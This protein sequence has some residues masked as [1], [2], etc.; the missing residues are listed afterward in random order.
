MLIGQVLSLGAL[1][2][3]AA[4]PQVDCIEA[5]S[6]LRKG[7][8]PA[9]C[10]IAYDIQFQGDAHRSEVEVS[11][12]SDGDFMY[13]VRDQAGQR[14][15]LPTYFVAVQ[16]DR[17]FSLEGSNSRHMIETDMT[18]HKKDAWG[19]AQWILCPWSIMEHIG[20][21]MLAGGDCQASWVDSD[22]LEFRSAAADRV[23]RIGR[24]GELKSVE[25][26]KKQ[27]SYHAVVAYKYKESGGRF[28]P[29]DILESITAGAGEKVRSFELHYRVKSWKTATI[30]DT[31]PD[32]F[33]PAALGVLRLDPSSGDVSSLDGK[34]LY[35]QA[36]EQEKFERMM[37]LTVEDSY[38]Y[39]YWISGGLAAVALV[40]AWKRRRSSGG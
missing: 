38:G 27:S 19:P 33:D 24:R 21:K 32:R 25:A 20:D 15:V 14:S 28:V 10:S 23:L 6:L 37:D 39:L 13:T 1:G 7:G 18:P 36:E 4:A 31:E 3:V 11:M 12:W 16:D 30:S 2:I 22:T 26:G 35:N 34:F 5:I 40:I 9:W 17:M 8:E 29:T